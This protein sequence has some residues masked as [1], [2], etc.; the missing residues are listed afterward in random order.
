MIVPFSLFGLEK[1]NKLPNEKVKELVRIL[2]NILPKYV[3]V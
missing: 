3:G 2:E 1:Y